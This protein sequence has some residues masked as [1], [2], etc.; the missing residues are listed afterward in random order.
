MK[1]KHDLILVELVLLW[2]HLCKMS[3][4]SPEENIFTKESNAINS[5]VANTESFR[6]FAQRVWI[7][8]SAMSRNSN[9]PIYTQI[10]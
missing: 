6:K 2:I 10:A 1:S 5:P 8:T 9:K 3:K 4:E 7:S